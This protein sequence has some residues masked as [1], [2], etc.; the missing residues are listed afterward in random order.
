MSG[1]WGGGVDLLFN[2][3]LPPQPSPDLECITKAAAGAR[4]G[5]FPLRDQEEERRKNTAGFPQVGSGA[6]HLLSRQSR[7]VG[8]G[9][10]LL[11]CFVKSKK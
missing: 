5:D 11:F 7:A 9:F 6:L 10:V 1:L 3:P 4:V 2:P 8:Q